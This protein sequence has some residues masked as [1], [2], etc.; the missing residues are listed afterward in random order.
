MV[1]FGAGGAT[2]VWRTTGVGATVRR[3]KTCVALLPAVN[4]PDR[5]YLVFCLSSLSFS[6]HARPCQLQHD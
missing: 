6:V 2:D 3:K 4:F 5:I 1:A